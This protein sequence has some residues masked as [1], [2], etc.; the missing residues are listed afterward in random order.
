MEKKGKYRINLRKKPPHDHKK[1]LTKKEGG[2]GLVLLLPFAICLLDLKIGAEDQ[3]SIS[4]L[5]E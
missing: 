4:E 5:T 3:K 1:V 2:V